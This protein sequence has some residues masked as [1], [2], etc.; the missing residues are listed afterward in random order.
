M[1]LDVQLHHKVGHTPPVS[2]YLSAKANPAPTG[3]CPLQFRDHHEKTFEKICI[4]PP[5]PDVPVTFPK[6]QPSRFGSTPILG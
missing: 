2:K 5:I 6:V 1:N 3:I 4:E